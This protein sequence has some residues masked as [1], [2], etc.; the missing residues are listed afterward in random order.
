MPKEKAIEGEA[1]TALDSA[2]TKP[3][4]RMFSLIIIFDFLLLAF[5]LAAVCGGLA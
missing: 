3:D 1:S 5:V 2:L 4:Y